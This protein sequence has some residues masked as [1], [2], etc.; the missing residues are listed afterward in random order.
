ML[1]TTEEYLRLAAFRYY[2]RQFLHFSDQAA[3]SAALEPQQHQ[4]LLALKGLPNGMRPTVTALAERMNLRHNSTVELANR[5]VERGFLRKRHGEA[6][7]R[8]VLLEM[9]DAGENTLQQ[10]SVMHLAELRTAGPAL[11][12]SLQQILEGVP[13]R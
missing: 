7:R 6:D 5:L 8:E 9:T 10:L 1:I 12:Q 2:V 4:F 11:L 13:S 3:R